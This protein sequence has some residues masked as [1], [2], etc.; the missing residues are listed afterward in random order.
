MIGG[1]KFGTKSASQF[2]SLSRAF[3]LHS[4][5]R[6]LVFFCFFVRGEEGPFFILESLDSQF[7]PQLPD[8]LDVFD[9]VRAPRS[10]GKTDDRHWCVSGTVFYS[11][12]VFAADFLVQPTGMIE[13]ADYSPLVA[14]SP[15]KVDAPLVL[16]G[17]IQA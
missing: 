16:E 15:D 13:M 1:E 7:L 8:E 14:D 11:N 6:Y 4:C 2:S 5:K 9:Y 3:S 12:A 10:W 17:V